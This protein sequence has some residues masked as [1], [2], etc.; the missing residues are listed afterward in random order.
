MEKY[1]KLTNM[2]ILCCYMIFEITL[3]F[4]INKQKYEN[5]D[6]FIK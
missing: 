6:T 3:K 5:N 2:I 1:K 4:I